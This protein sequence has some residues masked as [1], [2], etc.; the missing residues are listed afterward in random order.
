MPALIVAAALASPV[1]VQEDTQ[2]DTALTLRVQ[3]PPPVAF[4]ST[5]LGR[6]THSIQLVVWNRGAQPVALEPITVHFRP[7]RDSIVFTCDEPKSRDDRW[8]ASLEAGGTFAFSREVTCDTPLPGRYDVEIRARPRDAAPSAERI[9]GSFPLQIDPG[10]NPP[11]RIPWKPWLYGAASGT[12]DMRPSTDPAAAHIVVALIN[13]RRAPVTLTPLRA[14]MRITRRGS[15]IHACPD[16]SVDL[17]F[18]GSLAPGRMQSLATPLGCDISP[19]GQYDVVVSVANASGAKVRLATHGIRVHVNT[20]SSP[21][22]QDNPG[23]PFGG[24]S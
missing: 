11:V 19:E 10:P 16:H 7:M 20:P 17:A 14:T 22:V 12:K 6:A 24:G 21:G 15:S 3:D 9:Y 1:L 4:D 2:E 8:P 23:T 18:S 5:A 13:A